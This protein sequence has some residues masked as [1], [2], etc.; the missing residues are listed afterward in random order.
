MLASF[1]KLSFL[2]LILIVGAAAE[3]VFK[4]E[5]DGIIKISCSDASANAV[6]K[7]NGDV[8]KLVNLPDSAILIEYGQ[9]IICQC[10]S[11]AV[12]DTVTCDGTCTCQKCASNENDCSEP[13]SASWKPMA[14]GLVSVVAGLGSLLVL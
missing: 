14:F 10:P 6:C 12:A 13:C 8:G 3:S 5:T 9:G 4:L 7:R 11:N 2:L 1:Q